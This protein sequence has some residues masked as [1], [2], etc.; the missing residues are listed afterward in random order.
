[1]IYS[2]CTE[3]RKAK[4]KGNPAL[5][6]IDFLEVLD[7]DEVTLALGGPRQQTLLV[8]CLNPLTQPGWSAANV[9]VSGGESITQIGIDWVIPAAGPFPGGAAAPPT[10]A[11]PQEVAYFQALPDAANVIVVRT[12]VAGDFSTYSL[13]LVNDASQ[14][15]TDPFQVTEVLDGF[16]TQLAEVD[17]CFKVEC[18][19]NFDCKPPAADCAPDLPAPPPINYLAKDY[20]SFRTVIL[21]RLNQLLPAWAGTSEADLGVTLAELVAY[22]G[23]RLSYK[24]DAVATEAYIETA[25]RRVSLRRHAVLVDYHVHDGCNARAWIQLTVA[26]AG[27]PGT[28]VHLAGGSQTRFYTTVP[29]M[30]ASL[31]PGSGNEEAALAAGVQFFEAMQDADLYPEH[32]LL[33]F[34]TWGDTGCCLPAGATEAT[35][36][37]A[38]PNL[39]PGDVLIFEEVIG[40]QTGDAADADLRHRC[41][42]RLTQ[43]A[44]QDAHGDPLEDALFDPSSPVPLT[45]IQWAQDDALPFPLCLSSSYIRSDGTEANLTDVSVAHG[46]VVLADHGLSFGSV[47]LGTV[48]EPSLYWPPDLT[49]DRCTPRPRA[50]LPVRFNPEV[51]DSPLTQAVALPTAGVPAAPGVV[52]LARQGYVS[53]ADSGGL[54]SLTVS[55]NNPKGWPPLIGIVAS[56]NTATPANID[57]RV[58]YVPQPPAGTPA[59]VLVESFE[60]LSLTASDPN[61]AGTRLQALSQLVRVPAA[62]TPSA[63]PSGF[64]AA[65]TMLA[66]SGSV[67]LQDTGGV[68]YLAIEPTDPLGWPPLFGVITQANPTALNPG[69]FSLLVVYDPPLGGVGVTLPV[70]VALDTFASPS[71]ANGPLGL[72]VLDNFEGRPNAGL[73][74][75]ELMSFDPDQ[76]VPVI[77]LSGPLAGQA[78]AWSPLQDL[79]E[80][81]PLDAVFV[82]EIE[83]DGTAT[84]RFGDGASGYRPDPGSAF[85]AAYRVGNGTAGNVGADSL[86][87]VAAPTALIQACRNPLP[88]AG[89]ADPESNDQIRRRAPQAFLTQERAVTMADYEAVAQTSTQVDRAVATLRWTGAWYTVFVAVEPVGAGPLTRPLAKALKANLNRY[90]LAGQDLELDSPQYVSLEIALEICVDPDY[91]QSDV[92]A[93]LNQVLSDALLPNGQRGVFYPDNFTFGQTVYLSPVYAAARSVPGVVTVVAST[94][95]PQGVATGVYL[96]AGEMKMGPT[97]VARLAN[98]PNYPD[99]GQLTLNLEGGKP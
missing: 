66:A 45:E 31:R 2:C 47:A 51:P 70:T 67:N 71:A 83:S 58:Y 22:I 7:T 88:A 40:P 9:V 52:A 94:F 43:V 77:T 1:V 60:N 61:Y 12:S 97:Q 82:V 84:I 95:Q 50:A 4:V 59:Q 26:P 91:F 92:R 57:L 28:A 30:P 73:S 81:G 54:V 21:D 65:P 96:A 68:T 46:N 41:A 29:G 10:P 99:H 3:N 98:D 33:K 86:V 93:A 19:A 72:V 25:R 20:G 35:L 79:L 62:F 5:N 78:A 16:D 55:A 53:L 24:Q 56:A 37:G 39:Q 87:N 11:T 42:V 74:A 32:N 23:D 36:N 6:G 69:Q 76:A 44:T 64:P 13:R 49:A 89:G 38:Y 48:P 8:H 15:A 17:F 63:A 34:Y 75:A 27:P 18:P 85:T 80:S 14:A 90:R